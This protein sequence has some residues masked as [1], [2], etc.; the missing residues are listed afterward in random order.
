MERRADIV[1]SSTN[2]YSNF[3]LVKLNFAGPR[4]ISINRG[5]EYN[6]KSWGDRKHDR[7]STV[8]L[9]FSPRISETK[10]FSVENPGAQ[11]RGTPTLRHSIFAARFLRTHV[12]LAS[13]VPSREAIPLFF[14]FSTRHFQQ[15]PPSL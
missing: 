6:R 9:K 2:F 12:F 14:R 3:W 5:Q 1:T 4:N 11:E 15:L 10:Y 7:L 13:H 8:I